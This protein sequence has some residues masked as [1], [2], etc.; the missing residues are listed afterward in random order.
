MRHKLFF[1]ILEECD[2]NMQTYIHLGYPKNASTTLQTDV[3]PNIKNAFYLGRHYGSNYPFKSEKVSKAFYNLTMYDSIDCDLDDISTVI[4]EYVSQNIG[5]KDKLIISSESFAN[6]MVDRGLLA[7][8]LKL[9]F[10]EAKILMLIREQ[11]NALRSMYSFLVMQRGK[12]I[13]IAY[14][15]PSVDSFEKWIVEQ[16]LFFGKSFITT[17]KYYEYISVYAELFG[18]E[19]IT[20]LL[21]EELVHSPQTFYRKLNVFFDED[22]ENHLNCIDTPFRNKGLSKR[23]LSYY[24]FRGLFPNISLST[25]SPIFVNKIWLKFLNSG[26]QAAAKEYLPEDIESRLV[27]LYKKGNKSLQENYDVDVKKYGYNI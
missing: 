1:P 9:I 25:Y 19:N 3:F 21:F 24:R 27:S 13:N 23:A 6:N 20:V 26:N 18:E 5:E 22:L 8:R 7:E 12:N 2:L 14:G 4:H 17:L 11:I 15:R 16:E 10:P